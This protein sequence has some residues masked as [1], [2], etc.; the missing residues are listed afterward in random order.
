MCICIS[1]ERAKYYELLYE[2]KD[3]TAGA[4]NISWFIIKSP[5]VK[6]QMEKFI[7]I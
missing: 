4:D 7:N 5:L 1:I 6:G 3:F 2:N